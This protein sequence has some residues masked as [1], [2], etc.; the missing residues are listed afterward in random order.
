MIGT[1]GQPML[2][3]A[4]LRDLVELRAGA[5]RYDP[6]NGGQW[7]GG[8]VERIPFRGCVLPVSEDDLKTAPQGTY[9]AESRKI[10]TNGHALRQGGQVYDPLEGVTYLVTGDLDHGAVHPLRRFIVEGKG[11]AA[12]R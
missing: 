4:L 12:G 6:D 11:A 7:S 8:E 10:Y 9:T 1:F 5:G 3:N 2:P